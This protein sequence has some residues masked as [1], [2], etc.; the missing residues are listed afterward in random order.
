MAQA[1]EQLVG[2]PMELGAFDGILA[3]LEQGSAAAIELVG[4]PGI[5]KT[6]LLRELADR[7]DAR[8]HLV[9][10]GSAS[11]LER[12]LPFW[13]FVDALDEY[14]EG[15][16]P[17]RIEHLDEQTRAELAH[18]FPSLSPLG[19]G[20]RSGS[21]TSGTAPTAPCASCWRCLRRHS[22]WS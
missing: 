9:L 2:R 3:E 22:R 21:R 20:A 13:V 14:A 12:D 17:R 5:G 10:S 6:R 1:A 8:G 19:G 4:E 7:A 15:L 16:D 11:E 18:V